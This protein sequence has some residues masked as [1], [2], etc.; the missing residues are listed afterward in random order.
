MDEEKEQICPYLSTRLVP[1][2]RARARA[3]ARAQGVGLQAGT[4][5]SPLVG[6]MDRIRMED[7]GKPFK[8]LG[9]VRTRKRD[10]LGT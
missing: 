3:C 10:T 7:G 9:R 1:R 5:A 4:E 6:G 8:Y 2:A